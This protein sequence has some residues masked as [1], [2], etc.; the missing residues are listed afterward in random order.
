MLHYLMSKNIPVLE[1]ETARILNL[2]M[3]PYALQLYNLDK[4]MVKS[5]ISNR[6]LPLSRKN[7]EL[8]YMYTGLSREHEEFRL[9][10][11]THGLSINDNYWIAGEDEIGK[12]KYEDISIFKNSFN[13]AMYIVALKGEGKF[14]ITD[15]NISAEYTGQG[16]FPKC[17]V[18]EKD[19]IYLY[20]HSSDR[21]I[22][23][24]IAA[25]NIAKIAGLKTVDYEKATLYDVKCTKSK[26]V[27]NES[28]NWE[29][30]FDLIGYTDQFVWKIPQILAIDKFKIETSNM[31]IFDGIV[32][33]DDRHMKNWGFAFNA[34]TNKT[35][36][37]TH[38]YDYN[39]CFSYGRPEMSNLIYD[40]LKKMGVLRAARYAYFNYGTTL[41]INNII[42]YVNSYDLKIDRKR[43]LNRIA[44]IR[45]EKSN[46]NDCYSSVLDKK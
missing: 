37:L 45:G 13:K 19:G 20:K 39:N 5:W 26:I 14:T 12:I 1:I 6:A 42:N 18:R 44:Y 30:A 28:V 10:C 22:N 4:H 25:A 11:L 23:N 31:A 38:S 34:D 7:A 2:D 40:G 3:T 8:I 17:F 33:N 29:T 27:T 9:M 36:G 41:N 24:E 16:T 32:L 43:L 35:V 46:M 15:K 21:G